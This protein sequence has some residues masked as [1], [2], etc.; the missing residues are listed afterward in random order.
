M[1]HKTVCGVALPFCAHFLQFS[2]GLIVM[3]AGF[4]AHTGMHQ[5]LSHHRPLH[6]IS[7]CLEQPL[8]RY[9][10]L[11]PF[12]LCPNATLL[13]ELSWPSLCKCQPVSPALLILLLLFFYPSHVSSSNT[14]NDSKIYDVIIYYLALLPLESKFHKGGDHCHFCSLI[15]LPMYLINICWINKPPPPTR[16]ACFLCAL[17]TGHL[18]CT[19]IQSEVCFYAVYRQLKPSDTGFELPVVGDNPEHSQGYGWHWGNS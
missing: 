5:A 9:Y 18:R 16:T 6:R 15:S 8:S 14:P 19:F 4:H 12:D 2:P 17:Q 1:A 13:H 10:C 3:A 7:L 11:T